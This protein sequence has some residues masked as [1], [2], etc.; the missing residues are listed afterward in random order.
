[1]WRWIE[2]VCPVF[3]YI[4]F[5]VF[6]GQWWS[7]YEFDTDEGINLMKAALVAEGYSLYDEIWSDQPPVL[8]YVLALVHVVSDGSVAA[9]RTLILASSS[10]LIWSLFRIIFRTEG[11]GAAWLA[12]S[13]LAAS[14]VFQLLSVSVMVGLPAIALAVAALDHALLAADRDQRKSS[15]PNVSLASQRQVSTDKRD[16]Q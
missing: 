7:F 9:A 12:V 10:L 4:C 5:I 15:H 14:F 13:V 8:T 6:A 1:M 2:A 11:R 3:L 16:G